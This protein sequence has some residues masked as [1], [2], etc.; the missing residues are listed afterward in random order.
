MLSSWWSPTSSVICTTASSDGSPETSLRSLS[1]HTTTAGSNSTQ[2]NEHTDLYLTLCLLQLRTEEGGTLVVPSGPVITYSCSRL[3]LERPVVRLHGG[4]QR[5][6]W[7][8]RFSSTEWHRADKKRVHVRLHYVELTQGALAYHWWI[9]TKG[10]FIP[11]AKCPVW[12]AS[13]ARVTLAQRVDGLLTRV[14]SCAF[15]EEHSCKTS[16]GVEVTKVLRT[17]QSL[18][19]G[20]EA[21]SFRTSSGTEVTRPDPDPQPQPEPTPETSGDAEAVA[22]EVPSLHIYSEIKRMTSFPLKLRAL[23]Q[24]F[25]TTLSEAGC[26]YSLREAGCMMLEDLAALNDRDVRLFQQLYHR[27]LVTAESPSCGEGVVEELAE[28]G[29]Q[30]FN[31]MD[32]IFEVVLLR[33]QAGAEPQICP[34]PGGFLHHLMAVISSVSA[35]TRQSRPR[36]DQCLLLVRNAMLLFLE[37]V[38]TLEESEYSS[39][40]S[41][42]R[43]V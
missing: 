30:L 9:H 23:R 21:W 25:T 4:M 12:T 10:F 35:V 6:F 37:S 22:R 27:L 41:L 8:Q 14:A 1:T 16:G 13:T 3:F 36:A 32:V 38:F 11:S 15:T 28:I 42:F 17:C 24:A 5:T 33:I 2:Y 29:I 31:F 7:T 20:Q 19:I 43:A 39:P 34:R 40:G 18:F 26:R